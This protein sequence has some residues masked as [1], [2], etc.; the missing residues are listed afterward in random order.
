MGLNLATLDVAPW[1]RVWG[2]GFDRLLRLHTFVAHPTGGRY[3]RH[4][5]PLCNLAGPL[6]PCPAL[7]GGPSPGASTQVPFTHYP[8]LRL[9]H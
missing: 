5:V 9:S 2:L 3:I 8:S 7:A 1:F 4:N 6:P